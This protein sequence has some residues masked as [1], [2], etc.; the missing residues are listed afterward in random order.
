MPASKFRKIAVPAQVAPFQDA[1]AESFDRILG[2]PILNS[3][4]LVS[5]LDAN[6]HETLLTLTTSYQNIP[7]KLGRAPLGWVLVSPNAAATVM[8]DPLTPAPGVG[9]PDVEKFLRLKAS[10]TVTC[11]ILV[12]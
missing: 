1:C 9:N 2:L 11:R 7:H 3:L 4:L 8:E 10:A 12:F 5:Q 6:G